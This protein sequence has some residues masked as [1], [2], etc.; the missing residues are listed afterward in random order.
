MNALVFVLFACWLVFVY[1]MPGSI[2]V[3]IFGLLGLGFAISTNWFMKIVFSSGLDFASQ[4][5]S[6][7]D[8]EEGAAT[9]KEVKLTEEKKKA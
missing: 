2:H 5:G 9:A 3:W 8:D 7:P 6:G 4:R 1:A